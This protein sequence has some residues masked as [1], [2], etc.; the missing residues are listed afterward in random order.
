MTLPKH[1]HYDELNALETEGS[2]CN[3][4]KDGKELVDAIVVDQSRTGDDTR[5][6]PVLESSSRS[7]RATTEGDNET[8][9]SKPNDQQDWGGL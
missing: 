9:N 3:N 7:V 1:A 2:L 5:V 6:L 8:S 4:G